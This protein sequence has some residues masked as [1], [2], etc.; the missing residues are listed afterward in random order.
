MIFKIVKFEKLKNSRNFTMWKVIIL[1]I[2]KLLKI[3]GVRIIV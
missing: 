1:Q 2:K 3:W